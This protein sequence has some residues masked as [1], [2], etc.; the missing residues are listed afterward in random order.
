MR[1]PC[2]ARG[3]QSELCGLP[4]LIYLFLWMLQPS[5][6]ISFDFSS[7][8]VG[9]GSMVIIYPTPVTEKIQF[10]NWFRGADTSAKK[11]ILGYVFDKEESVSYGPEYTGRESGEP[12]GALVITYVL[13]NYTSDYTLQM[14]LE[15]QSIQQATV[16][17][18]V[19][20]KC[21][22]QIMP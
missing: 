8:T 10:Y 1:T 12:D 15:G 11:M 20:G 16:H 5:A 13:K 17:L 19:S 22:W 3:R 4:V 18:T 7:L 6:Q 2:N 14:Q 21:F 9:E